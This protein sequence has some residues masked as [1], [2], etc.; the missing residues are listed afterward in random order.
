LNIYS[1]DLAKYKE[2]Y[3]RVS[4]S[5][6]VVCNKE[7]EPMQLDHI[8]SS[9]HDIYTEETFKQM[10]R[11]SKSYGESLADKISDLFGRKP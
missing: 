7:H 8:E 10:D 11:D 9:S 5:L 1:A 4:L 3:Q 6:Q 2:K